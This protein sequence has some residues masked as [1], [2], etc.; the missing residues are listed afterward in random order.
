[1]WGLKSES[2]YKQL[3]TLNNCLVLSDILARARLRSAT[4][5]VFWKCSYFKE[6]KRTFLFKISQTKLFLGGVVGETVLC[7]KQPTSLL[8]KSARSVRI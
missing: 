7:G 1:M 5:A 2:D 8:Y 3:Q 4:I 6:Q